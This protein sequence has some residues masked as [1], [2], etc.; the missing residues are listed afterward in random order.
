MQIEVKLCIDNAEGYAR[1]AQTLASHHLKDECYY[2][3]FFD[4][5]YR[6]L[7]ERNSVLRLR[8]PCELAN[9][10]AVPLSDEGQPSS[11]TEASGNVNRTEDKTAAATAVEAGGGSGVSN[12]DPDAEYEAFLR[13]CRG[14]GTSD[15]TVTRRGTAGEASTNGATAV[16]FNPSAAARLRVLPRPLLV[17]GA[18]GKLFLKQKNTV[19]GGHQ[20]NFVAEDDDVPADVVEALVHL[21]PESLFLTGTVAVPDPPAAAGASTASSSTAENAFRILSVY[22]QR[23]PRVDGGDGDSAI[24][25]IVK[26]LRE[27]ARVYTPTA[28]LPSCVGKRA[29]SG[30]QESDAHFTQVRFAAMGARTA[31]TQQQLGTSALDEEEDGQQQQQQLQQ[32][33]PPL[34]VPVGGFLTLRRIYAYTGICQGVGEGDGKPGSPQEAELREA[35]R[36]RLDTSFLLPG[37][38]IYEL[39]VPKCGVVVEDVK[40]EVCNFLAKLGVQYHTGSES[41]YARY[42]HYLAATREEEHDAMDVKLR[43]TNVNGYTEVRRNLQRLTQPAGSAVAAG[44]GDA[45]RFPQEKRY[46]SNTEVDDEDGEDGASDDTWWQTNP[47]GYLQEINEDFFF[48]S[49]GQVLRR[50]QTF[51]RLR[52]QRHL[53][54]YFLVLK[55]HQVFSGGQQKSLSSTLE[56]S[57]VVARALIDHPTQFLRA[58]YDNFPLMKTIWEEFGVRELCRTATFTTERLTVPWWSSTTQPSTLPRSWA[59]VSAANGQTIAPQSQPIYASASYL[60]SQQ[61]QQQQQ[62]EGGEDIERRV[63]QPPLVPP[64]LIHLD[65]T[66]YKLPADVK[67]ARAPFT[68]SRPWV[69]RQ[70]ETYEIEVTNIDGSTDPKE[71]VNELTGLLNGLGVEWT[72]GVRSKLEQ[73]FTL[74][75][76]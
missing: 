76:A 18:T 55:A 40:E 17:A 47:N 10:A 4:Y 12:Y 24:A 9:V 48:D 15:G 2:D 16:V 5:C 59:S 50:G 38:A 32:Q 20:M 57:E 70:C 62:Q 26:H 31:F 33:Q 39:E 67:V 65:K 45:P 69:D 51:L 43:L 72:V 41:K 53:N 56:L 13:A 68:Q 64:L 1:T 34:L 73:Y 22:A 29:R 61:Q 42:V 6:A 66:M 75:D 54:K 27:I 71:V 21:V 7:Q 19:Q 49:P 28:G 11:T 46:M 25:R 58:H 8:V 63:T 44:P 14:Q 23:R 36:V 52:K 60:L 35:L 74:I 3:F 30:S 37:F